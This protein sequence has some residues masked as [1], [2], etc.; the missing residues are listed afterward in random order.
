MPTTYQLVYC[1]VA[2]KEMS[3]ND[4]ED[5]LGVARK[6]NEQDL[7][8]NGADIVVND[9]SNITIDDIERWFQRK[10][11]KSPRGI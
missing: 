3:K 9:M 6:N 11:I 5:L 7:L 4:L 2:S 1:S 8:D 10:P